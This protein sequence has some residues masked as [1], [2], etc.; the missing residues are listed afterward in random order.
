MRNSKWYDMGFQ[1][2][3]TG[4]GHDAPWQKGHR[5]HTAYCEGYMDGERQA[6][7]EAFSWTGD[8]EE[9]A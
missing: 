9:V 2:A 8:R 1:D 3:R 6:E 4:M 5:D 7:R